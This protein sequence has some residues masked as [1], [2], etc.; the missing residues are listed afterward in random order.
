LEA[1][2]SSLVSVGHLS[3]VDRARRKE[4]VGSAH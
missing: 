1:A 4:Q 3:G 2:V